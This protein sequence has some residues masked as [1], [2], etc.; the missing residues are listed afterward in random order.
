M[1]DLPRLKY[2]L[3]AFAA[4]RLAGP[5]ERVGVEQARRDLRR[6]GPG[7]V[8]GWRPTLESIRDAAVAGVRV[9]R[10]VPAG[11]AAGTVVFFHGGGWVLGDLQSH[12]VL[13]ARLATATRRIVV[14]VDY[15]LAPEDTYPAAIE[16]A[17]TVFDA[18]EGPVV[19]AGDSAGGNLA[20]VVAN[21]RRGGV[22]AQLLAYPVVDCGTEHP[23][24][25]AFAEGHFLTRETMRFFT[26]TYVPDAARRVEPRCSPLRT[27]SLVG[28][29]P[30]YVLL[31]GCDPLRDEG[32]AYAERLGKAGVDLMVDEVPGTIHGFFSMQGLRE[33]RGA[34]ERMARWLELR[35]PAATPSTRSA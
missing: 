19:V 6:G 24:Y 31:A 34:L 9:R 20:A 4:A 33:G 17:L 1:S 18:L 10:Y 5:V 16:D 21:E 30:A 12:D 23:S 7:F 26:R 29:P 3:L 22:A 14:S 8:M 13:A 35:W 11:A 25:A 27:P 2:R 28:A 15:R 32:R